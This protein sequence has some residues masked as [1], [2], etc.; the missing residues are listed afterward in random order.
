MS[1]IP[2]LKIATI[3][4]HRANVE[5]WLVT[6]ATLDPTHPKLDAATGAPVTWTKGN[7]IEILK[8]GETVFSEADRRHQPGQSVRLTSST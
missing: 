4:M 6:N 3:Q 7:R 5:G 1:P 2:V 8:D